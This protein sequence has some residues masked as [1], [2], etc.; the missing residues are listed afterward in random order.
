[1]LACRAC[2]VP[3]SAQGGCAICK[4]FK[5][6]L[7]DTA[8]DSEENPALSDVSY[9]TISALRSVLKRGKQLVADPT[10][11]KLFNEGSRL[12]VAAANTLAKVLD[13]SR[14]LQADGLTAIQRMN[15]VERAELFIGWYMTLPPSYRLKLRQQMDGQETQVAKAL[16][17]GSTDG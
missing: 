15:F 7:V 16:P 3:I 4:D 14:K 13:T 8:E 2:R 6:Q 17:A 12:I 1:M 11:V 5:S 10:K 9:E